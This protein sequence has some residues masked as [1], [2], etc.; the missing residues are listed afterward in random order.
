MRRYLKL[1]SLMLLACALVATTAT[2][3]ADD[4]KVNL[5]LSGVYKTGVFDESA[6][7]IVA[8]DPDNN[9]IFVVNGNDKAIDILDASDPAN[10]TK[11]GVLDVS[12][13]GGG[14]NS[15]AVK[16]GLVAAAVENSDKQADGVIAVFNTK[17]EFQTQFAAGALPDM[18]T[19]SPNGRYILAANEG[20]PNDDYTVDPEGSITVVDIG[21]GLDQ[22]VVNQL[23]FT[24]F[25]DQKD[26]LIN[27][28]V[29]IF[30]PAA[31]VAMDVEPEYIAVAPNS[32]MA[33]CSLQ[34]N[35]AIAAIDLQSMAITAILPLGYKDY[36]AHPLDASNKDNAINIRS[37]DNV[38]GMYQPDSIAV[39]EKDDA[40]YL[41]TANEGDS[42]DYDGYSEETR[43]KDVTLDPAAFPDAATLQDEA[44]LG[45]LKMT[46]ANGDIDGDGDYDMIYSFGGRSFGIYKATGTSIEQVY[47]SSDDF[48]QTLASMYPANF[49]ST[50]NENNSFDN[51]SDDK[52][53]EPEALALGIFDDQV[54]A[55]IGLER[56]GGI[57]VYDVTN[58]A[59]PVFLQYMNTRN[60]DGNPEAG[61]AGN[62]APEG[63]K[64]V[65]SDDSPTGY[66]LLLAAYEVSG[67]TAIFRINNA[68]D[69][70]DSGCTLAPSAKLSLDWL[71]L[72][73]VP[74]L[75]LLRRRCNV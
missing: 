38:A 11:K 73:A 4:G 15:V 26:A 70:G 75:A 16:N 65:D 8:Y 13:Y 30:G 20:E 71:L 56:M 40:Y 5:S 21:N 9:Q 36:S 50:D 45:R 1:W 61:T 32:E 47:D 64:V 74:A 2:A 42:R 37:Y 10:P 63:M 58:P 31:T 7:E 22:A 14:V 44:L 6:A 72:L 39:F 49:N 34:E 55:F 27:A 48:A 25:N 3:N 53:S 69:G 52:G 17:G 19:F 43:V 57:M 62:L 29:R 59:S 68:P 28:G 35:N 54:F 23:P 33:W 51:R 60:Y 41:V 12:A 24:G 66:P 18:V 67:S 46:T